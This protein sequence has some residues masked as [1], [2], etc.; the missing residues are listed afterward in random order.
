MYVCLSIYLAIVNFKL[1]H[2]H[3]FPSLDK[4]SLTLYPFIEVVL[5]GEPAV[6]CT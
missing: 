2:Y 4:P 6:P 1:I 3:P 5:D